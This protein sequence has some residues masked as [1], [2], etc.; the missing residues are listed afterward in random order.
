MVL[1]PHRFIKTLLILTVPLL[2]GVGCA[3]TR[4]FVPRPTEATLSDHGVL[5]QAKRR[6]SLV[7]AACGFE[8]RDNGKEIGVLGPGGQLEWTR[9]PGPMK[10]DVIDTLYNISF[11]PLDI[12]TKAGHQYELTLRPMISTVSV[13]IQPQALQ[14]AANATLVNAT[15]TTSRTGLTP[16][17]EG[18]LTESSG[19]TPLQF[20]VWH[21]VQVFDEN[22]DV[23]G[24]RTSLFY[25]RNRDIYGIDFSLFSNAADDIYGLSIQV[26]GN[27][28][29]HGI[30][31]FTYW[32]LEQKRVPN[33]HG[34]QI[35]GGAAGAIGILFPFPIG[36]Y[37]AISTK[38]GN[39]DGAQISL[40]GNSALKV[41]GIQLAG[42]AN[43]AE[44]DLT[45]LQIAAIG[46]QA[47]GEGVA[48]QIGGIGNLTEGDYGGL[49][50]GLFGNHNEG[51]Y[52]G[53]QLSG[54]L[55]NETC[56]RMRGFQMNGLWNTAGDMD[57]V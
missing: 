22:T 45:G 42:I 23:Y 57:G 25:G 37:A 31:P 19:W 30:F 44:S 7:G 33:I 56:G 34:I 51:D 39:V 36:Y 41:R 5:V 40:I 6:S 8:V 18:K 21:P 2:L 24:L 28:L 50:L 17:N 54:L 12:M 38:A 53:L 16:P 14:T 29:H 52:A 47:N 10:I 11:R 3:S 20:A 48:L 46:N 4:Q 49:Q 32:S 35:G 9:L 55:G 43:Y 26:F 1:S 27:K 13:R 15:P